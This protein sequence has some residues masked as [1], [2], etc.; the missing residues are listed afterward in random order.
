MKIETLAWEFALKNGIFGFKLTVEDILIT[1]RK[2]G[3]RIYSYQE[4]PALLQ[5]LDITEYAEAKLGLTYV[6]RHDTKAEYFIFYRDELPSDL[7][8]FVILHELGHIAMQHSF[9]GGVL[10]KSPD[11]RLEK[12]QELEAD[13]FACEILAP[14]C[15]LKQLHIET[16]EEI[17]RLGI[18]PPDFVGQYASKIHGPDSTGGGWTEKQLLRKFRHAIRLYRTGRPSPSPRGYPF[19]TLFMLCTALSAF[20]CLFGCSG[21][22]SKSLHFSVPSAALQQYPAYRPAANTTVPT[23]AN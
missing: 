3:C 15:V 10:G 2:N 23:A 16:E 11:N 1:A 22:I 4:Y 13:L 7:K 6:L 5:E 19:L 8:L 12:R 18:L 17:R 21:Q 14:S 9:G 20:S